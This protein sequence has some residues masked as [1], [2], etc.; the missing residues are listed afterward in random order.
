[1]FDD[2]LCAKYAIINT[3]QNIVGN[4]TSKINEEVSLF[5]FSYEY[6][7]RFISPQN[8]RDSLQIKTKFDYRLRVRFS[9]G[10]LRGVSLDLHLYWHARIYAKCTGYLS[11]MHEGTGYYINERIVCAGTN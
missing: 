8:A 3:Q 1:M 10:N 11:I 2:F 7:I 5:H 6:L 4:Y 9:K